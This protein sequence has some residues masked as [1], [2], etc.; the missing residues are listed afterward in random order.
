MN[1]QRLAFNRRCFLECF[2][3]VSL[4]LMPGAL[5]AVAQDSPRITREMLEAAAKIAGVSFTREEQQAILTRLNSSA[6]PLPGFDVLRGADL[7]STQPAFVFNP[8]LPGKTL[9]TERR[10]IKRRAIEVSMPATD[11][12][13][14]FLPVT[15]LARLI[16]T[17]QIKPTDLTKLYLSRLKQYDPKLLCVVNL[18]EDLAQRQARR[19]DEE[20]AAG[21]Y[22][23][24]L[25][26]IPWGLKDLFAVR[27]TK[28]TWGMTPYRNRVIDVDSSVYTRLTD[29][30]AILVAKL[31]TGA[32]AVTARWFGGL[33]RN[34]WNTEQ[35]ASGSSAGPGSATAAGLV[36]FSIGSDTGGSI[37][38]PASRNGV[39]GLR[40]TFGRVSRHGGMVLAWTQDTVGPIC[41]SAEDCALVFNAIYGPDGK[42]NSI[43]DVPFNWDA[44]A[45]VT[46]LRVGY[47][48]S[49][50]EGAV[51]DDFERATRANYQ[52]A[53]RVIRSLGV[54]VAPFDLPDVPI[55]A[56]DFIRYA[57]TAAFFDDVTRSGVLTQVEEGPE[58][59]TRPIEIRSAYFT[60]A[61]EFIQANRFRTRVMER[62]DEAM[63]GLDLFIGSQQLLTNRTGHP[64]VSV[65]SGYHGGLPTALH[66]TGKI[67]GDSEILLLAHAFQEATRH[68][69]RHPAL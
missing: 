65:P 63:S 68:H 29:A 61:V 39:T 49:A 19:A 28:T 38:G 5:M 8:V 46:R 43:I 55:S 13:L 4:A 15:H 34:P 53:L 31:S 30:G 44:S 48:R 50:F 45:D 47:L 60:P 56:I 37:I 22:R 3:G 52:E 35:D 23:G 6:G 17:R 21:T 10:P 54:N 41:R 9:P 58:R 1:E 57:E 40:P 20:I 33:T 59:S 51:T 16:E 32:L 14:A 24:P 27:G 7:G 26:G 62:M 11:E 36:G 69:L 42:D 12:E 66:F 64:V 25:H 18:T 2:S 67:F